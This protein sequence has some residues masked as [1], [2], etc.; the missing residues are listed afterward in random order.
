MLNWGSTC[1]A[2]FMDACVQASEILILFLDTLVA[3]NIRPNETKFIASPKGAYLILLFANLQCIFPDSYFHGVDS[4]SVLIC[5]TYNVAQKT[6]QT[7]LNEETK[8]PN[9]DALLEGLHSG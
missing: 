7:L 3:D 1:M 8:T 6:V 4:D 9:A 5:E 2:G